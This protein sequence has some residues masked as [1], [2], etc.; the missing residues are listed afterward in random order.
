MYNKRLIPNKN[1]SKCE[2]CGHNLDLHQSDAI[3]MQK[4]TEDLTET[5]TAKKHCQFEGCA[6][7]ID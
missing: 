3:T 2:K 5:L 1:M 6:C 7:S 4:G